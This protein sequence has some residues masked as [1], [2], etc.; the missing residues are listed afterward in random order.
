MRTLLALGLLVPGAAL[1]CDGMKNQTAANAAPAAATTAAVDPSHCAKNAELVGSNCSFSTGMMAQ[2]VLDEGTPWT[3]TGAL[4]ASTNQ[5]ASHV[6]A[7]W[8]VGPNQ[9]VHVVANE[10]VERLAG[11]SVAGRVTLEGR[12]LEVD[13]VKYFVATQAAPTNS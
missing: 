5:L 10:V 9:S 3:F 8:T 7:P 12:L 13:G 1:A 4:A 2:R 11:G 6:A